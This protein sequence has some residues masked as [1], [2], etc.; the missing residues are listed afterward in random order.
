LL[1]VF[2]SI[3]TGGDSDIAHDVDGGA[4]HIQ[5][6]IDSHDNPDAFGWN[7]DCLKD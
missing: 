4:R 5:E 1:L 3:D 6:S 7:I 2:P